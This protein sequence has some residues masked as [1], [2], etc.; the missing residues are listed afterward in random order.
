MDQIDERLKNLYTEQIGDEKTKTYKFYSDIAE[1]GEI[2]YV[3]TPADFSIKKVGRN[4]FFVTT[5][6]QDA[7]VSKRSRP[8]VEAITSLSQKSSSKQIDKLVKAGKLTFEEGEEMKIFKKRGR[9]SMTPERRQYLITFYNPADTKSLQFVGKGGNLVSSAYGVTFS[10]APNTSGQEVKLIA[11]KIGARQEM[12]PREV[13]VVESW[14][15]KFGRIIKTGTRTST[16][17]NYQRATDINNGGIKMEM[18]AI[19][20]KLERTLADAMNLKDKDQD[21]VVIPYYKGAAS[22]GEK[23]VTGGGGKI[24]RVAQSEFHDEKGR[25]LIYKD[26]RE[27]ATTEMS[28]EQKRNVNSRLVA[29]QIVTEG[30]ELE[31]RV[32]HIP[33]RDRNGLVTRDFL[34]NE[35][36]KKVYVISGKKMEVFPTGELRGKDFTQFVS[37]YKKPK[38]QYNESIWKFVG[39]DGRELDLQKVGLTAA[40]YTETDGKMFTT[41]NDLTISRAIL[42]NDLDPN[43]MLK[44]L[45]SDVAQAREYYDY[46]KKQNKEKVKPAPDDEDRWRTKG[47]TPEAYLKNAEDK[48]ESFK[49]FG[50]GDLD[51]LVQRTKMTAP[52]TMFVPRGALITMA[53]KDLVNEGFGPKGSPLAHNTKWYNNSLNIAGNHKLITVGDKL[54]GYSMPKLTKEDIDQIIL[55]ANEKDKVKAEV[56]QREFEDSI[57][58]G[59]K[60]PGNKRLGFLT[61]YDPETLEPIRIIPYDEEAK[62]MGGPLAGKIEGIRKK[63]VERSD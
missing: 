30:D 21:I 43:T 59:R 37:E 49:K 17:I 22:A 62:I 53:L 33:Q 28:D 23:D 15:R 2:M 14:I 25:P 13:N 63:T 61:E 3:P 60:R 19:P 44:D 56:M 41:I 40:P 12:E 45:E 31:G 27:M 52:Q 32:M 8:F 6:G 5:L 50:M 26:F 29:K 58:A 24:F 16:D 46:A 36:N 7:M 55:I 1:Q 34:Y 18:I 51:K 11:Q 54:Y 38:G 48:L 35:G 47:L 4:A 20:K 10:L 9:M 57:D 39:D 42:K